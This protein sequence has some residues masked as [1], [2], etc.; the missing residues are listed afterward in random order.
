[1][2]TPG[3]TPLDWAIIVL[4]ALSTLG[5]GYF[6]SRRQSSV[7]EYFTGS[8]HMSPMEKPEEFNAAVLEFM[9]ITES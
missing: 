4:Y 7:R 1:M 2:D 6:F 8:G 3:L 5:L 9:S